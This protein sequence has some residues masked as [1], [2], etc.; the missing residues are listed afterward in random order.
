M[1]SAVPKDEL[2]AALAR[3]YQREK[4]D[5]SKNSHELKSKLETSTLLILFGTIIIIISFVGMLYF[6]N[7]TELSIYLFVGAMIILG[8]IISIRVPWY[9]SQNISELSLK[10]DS[11]S[12]RVQLNTVLGAVFICMFV[13]GAASS[14]LSVNNS[15]LDDLDTE[16]ETFVI[17]EFILGNTYMDVSG[18]PRI[19]VVVNVNGP[20]KNKNDKVFV[21]IESW[22]AGERLE[23]KTKKLPAN[24]TIQDSL[25]LHDLEDTSYNVEVIVNNE[26]TDSFFKQSSKE[27]Y[28]SNAEVELGGFLLNY[29]DVTVTIYNDGSLLPEHTIEVTVKSTSIL[30]SEDEESATNDVAIDTKETW[31][32]T[33][34]VSLE[35]FE[36]EETTFDIVLEFK[37][38][39]IDKEK[40][41]IE[42]S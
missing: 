34:T 20:E 30:G 19:K 16:L 28:I 10:L 26:I 31:E 7:I 32:T 1:A 12:T 4:P 9:L 25:L 6:Q 21:N 3:V 37:E 42:A 24:N 23:A 2:K 35:Y 8:L 18:D 15:Q 27:L 5:L 13:I 40:I 33:I 38:R 17:D 11:S 22:F 14:F 41:I 39:L 36:G 29:A